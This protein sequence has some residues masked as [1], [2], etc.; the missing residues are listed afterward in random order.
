MCEER[1]GQLKQHNKEEEQN[2]MGPKGKLFNIDAI[3]LMQ[4]TI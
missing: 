3:D 1:Q 2:E 4:F